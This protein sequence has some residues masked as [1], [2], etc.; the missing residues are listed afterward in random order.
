MN[1]IDIKWQNY[2]NE[3]N[4]Q[5]LDQIYNLIK[6]RYLNLNPK[7]QKSLEDFFFKFP[8]WGKLNINNQEFEAL[9]NRAI[10]IKQ[11]LNDFINLYN[12]LKDYRSKKLLLGILKNWYEFDMETI[13]YGLEKNY[14]HYF[15][16]DIIP[17]N[18]NTVLVDIGAYTGDT[19]LSYLKNYNYQYKKIYAYEMTEQTFIKLQENLKNYNNIIYK[20]KAIS[21]K[22]EILSFSNNSVDAS[23]NFITNN[24]NNKIETTTIDEDINEK[25]SIIKM[26]IEGYEQK[27]LLGCKQ[28]IQDEHPNLLISVYHNHEDLW[29]IPKM[30]NDMYPDYDYYLRCHGN[31]IFPTEIVLFAINKKDLP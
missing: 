22:K 15:D 13:K 29:K 7:I 9:Y 18:Q 30:I 23:A 5:S 12:K 27:A 10:N 16:L 3:I 31:N 14:D 26:D 24:G 20:N 19:I 6:Q 17:N 2:I 4:S 8:Y 28:H 21:D 1:E 11:H 25:I